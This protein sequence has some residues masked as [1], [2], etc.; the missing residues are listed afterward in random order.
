M[1]LDQIS[2]HLQKIA[3][4]DWNRLFDFIPKIQT[5]DK[6]VVGGGLVKD[7]KDPDILMIT[8][9]VEAKVVGEFTELMYDLD[10]VIGFDWGKWDE[11]R[12]IVEKGVYKGLDVVTLLKL[13]TALIRNDRFCEGVLAGAMQ[14]GTIVKILEAMKKATYELN[15]HKK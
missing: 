13:L 7:P 8:P 5:C 1:E 14:D 3:P 6:F 2:S 4:G 9:I 10:L 11:G 15:I 12:E